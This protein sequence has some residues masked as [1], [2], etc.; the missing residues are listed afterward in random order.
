MIT[1][2]AQFGKEKLVAVYARVFESSP[3]LNVPSTSLTH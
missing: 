1:K 3:R 2:K